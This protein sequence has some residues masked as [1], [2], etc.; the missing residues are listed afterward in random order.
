MKQATRLPAAVTRRIAA[1]RDMLAVRTGF[2]H[3]SGP[4]RV[5]LGPQDVGL[6]AL[7]RDA[8][9]F[10]PD[11]LSH[12]LALGVAHVVLIDNGSTDATVALAHKAGPKVTVLRNTLPARRHEVA[13]RVMGARRVLRGGWF[14][15]ADADEMVELPLGTLSGLTAYCNAEGY[16]AVVG[17]MID[18]YDPSAAAKSDPTYQDAI[19]ACTRWSE[20][21]LERIPYHAVDRIPFNWFLRDNICDDPDVTLL[22]GGLRAEVFGERPFLSKHSLVR[23]AGVTQPMTHPHCASTVS[24][25]DITIALRHYKL[26]GDWIARDRKSVGERH[27]DHAEDQRRLQASEGQAFSIAPAAPREWLGA[28]DLLECGILH[29]S[30]KARAALG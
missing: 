5:L 26:A 19:A 24:I 18:L 22:R 9:W 6:V 4:A 25:A 1:M 7:V 15:F 23:N 12:H 17:Q 14:L 13:L 3:I 29:A 28:R 16:T 20:G 8:A 2:R 10:L 30:A 27:W 21:A 11:F